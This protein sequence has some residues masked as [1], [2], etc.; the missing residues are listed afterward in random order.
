MPRTNPLAYFT[1]KSWITTVK[2]FVT[3]GPDHFA[4]KRNPHRDLHGHQR[5]ERVPAAD[6]HA[7]SCQAAATAASPAAAAP[8]TTATSAAAP[9]SASQE[10]AQAG[11]VA[12][13]KTGPK[14][15]T[16]GGTRL[17]RV[18]QE[19]QHLKQPGQTQTNS[20]VGAGNPYWVG[21]LSTVDLLV[22]TTLSIENCIYLVTKQVILKRRPTV[23]SFPL[24]LVFPG[25]R[26][27][28]CSTTFAI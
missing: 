18:W 9:R 2:S 21:R 22:F 7:T 6:V 23:L 17:R 5:T 25:W 24:K 13:S 8:S 16:E 14:V 27:D 12:G 3:L 26:H 4:G 28:F 20:Q 10:A 15:R 11:T 1:K 19:V